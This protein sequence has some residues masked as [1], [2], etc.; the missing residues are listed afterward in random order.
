VNRE[1]IDLLVAQLIQEI[2]DSAG[3]RGLKLGTDLYSECES[4]ELITIEP[5]TISELPHPIQHLPAICKKL[6]VYRDDELQPWDYVFGTQP[7]DLS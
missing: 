3:N 1:A 2:D 6:A 5:F 4:L 7:D